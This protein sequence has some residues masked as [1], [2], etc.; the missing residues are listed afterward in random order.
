MTTER[1]RLS[2][3]RTNKL[4]LVLLLTAGYLAAEVIGAIF[5]GSLALLADA[6]HMLSDVGGLALALFAISFARRPAT[7]QRTYGF[8]RLEILASLTNSIVL[9]LLSI[10]IVYEAYTRITAPTQLIQVDSMPM[11]LVAVAGLGVNLV[12]MRLLGSRG[13]SHFHLHVHPQH[14]DHGHNDHSSGSN[15]NIK[16]QAKKEIPVVAK[17]LNIEAARLEVLSDTLGSIGVIAAGIIIMLTNIYVIDPLVSIGL[18][19]FIL[20]RT[21]SLM[22]KSIHILMEG[23]PTHVSYEEIS[24]AILGVKGVTG[25]FDLHIWSITSSIDALS[26]HVVVIDTSK[27]QAILQEINSLLEKQFNITHATIQ[28]EGY[29]PQPDSAI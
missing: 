12:G 1:D 21:W 18:A 8:Y 11:T 6:G 7:P 16:G 9:I 28:V 20:P 24:K 4:R 25:L 27:S 2:F 14:D 13:H 19:L 23:V 5:T 29:H 15:G 10:Y 17:D 26:A 3:Q 22:N